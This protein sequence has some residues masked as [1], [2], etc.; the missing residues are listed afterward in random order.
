MECLGDEFDF[1][2]AVRRVRCVGHVLNL[3]AK[4]IMIGGGSRNEP[5]KDVFEQQLESLARDKREELAQCGGV[6]PLGN[7]I[8][9]LCGSIG[10]RSAYRSSRLCKGKQ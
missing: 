3:V 10:H 7:S 4:A 9:S 6:A 2:H 5:D 8:T 1:D